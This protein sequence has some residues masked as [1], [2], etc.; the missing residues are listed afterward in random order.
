MKRSVRLALIAGGMAIVIGWADAVAAEPKALFSEGNAAYSEGRYEEARKAYAEAAASDGRSANLFFNLGNAEFRLGHR[1]AA[2]LNYERAL[3]LD[4]AHPEAKANLAFLRDRT[5]TQLQGP[6]GWRKLLG[7]VSPSVAAVLLAGS[8][9][10]MLLVLA[11]GVRGGMGWMAGAVLAALAVCCGGLLATSPSAKDLVFVTGTHV[12]ARLEPSASAKLAAQLP[13][14]SRLRV[15]QDSG[16]WVYCELPD[17][18]RGWVA[19]AE[20]GWFVPG[21]R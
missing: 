13:E 9:W 15:L 10:G 17:K 6:S 11:A 7:G 21:R 14:G 19:A 3:A 16:P 12:G 8:V 5:G 1:G 18:G 4:A 2:I 20:V